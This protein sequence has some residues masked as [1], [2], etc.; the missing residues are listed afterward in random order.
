[1][2]CIA[3]RN[4]ITGLVRSFSVFIDG[5]R[6]GRL[7]PYGTGRYL[8]LPGRHQISLRTG[9][10]TMPAKP[11]AD[12]QIAVG[13]VRTFHTRGRRL[14]LSWGLLTYSPDYEQGPAI[15]LRAWP[16]GSDTGDNEVS[17]PLQS[18]KALTPA[19]VRNAAFR[20]VL[21]GYDTGEVDDL[22]H[23]LASQMELGEKIPPLSDVTFHLVR[24]GYDVQE[25][26]AYLDGIGQAL[27]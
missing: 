11:L 10:R 3:R 23:K 17:S 14:V 9:K 18:P 12:F 21:K 16:P 2:V 22:L 7:W 5:E 25:V 1:M 8:V 13:E 6:V 20:K 24:N 4:L 26:D 15:K 19:A 27:P